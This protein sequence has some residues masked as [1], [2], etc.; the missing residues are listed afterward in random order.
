MSNNQINKNIYE[1]IKTTI[2]NARS[3]IYSTINFEMVLAYWNIGKQ[4]VEAQGKEKR[5][6]YGT[7]LITYLSERL[8]KEFGKG[9]DESNLKKMR[10]FYLLFQKGDAL[11]H[12]LSW[13]HYRVLLKIED[14]KKLDFYL[15]ECADQNW[16]TR[17]LEAIC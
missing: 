15:T 14:K 16:S 8:T 10:K 6:E 7:G 17:Q 5:A 11:R 3:K 12:Q 4:I 1:I 9:F 2:I 13:T